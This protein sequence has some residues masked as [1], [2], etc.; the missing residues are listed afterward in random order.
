MARNRIN[1]FDELVSEIYARLAV[2]RGSAVEAAADGYELAGAMDLLKHFL[3]LGDKQTLNEGITRLER[4]FARRGKVDREWG[5]TSIARLRILAE[6]MQPS[7]REITPEADSTSLQPLVSSNPIL[8][9]PCDVLVVAALLDPELTAFLRCLSDVEQ[10]VGALD[11]ELPSVTYYRGTLKA[12]DKQ[13]GDVRKLSV[14]ALFQDRTGMVDC[15][16]LVTRAVRVFRPML[17]AMTGVC[18]GRGKAGVRLC[19]LVIPSEVFTH[20]T[21]KQ[22]DLGFQ[23]EPLWVEVS[24]RICRRVKATGET[25][26]ERL[27]KE[28]QSTYPEHLQKPRLHTE[29]MACGSAVID[30]K[31]TM[32]RVGDAHRKVVGLDMESYAVLRAVKLCSP[33]TPAFIV[34]GVMDLGTKKRDRVKSKAAFWAGSFLARFISQEYDSLRMG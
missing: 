13:P 34:K 17:V 31:D 29:V 8:P 2:R 6:D 7:D 19:D 22:G 16:V 3:A 33:M 18:A 30:H 32:T 26:L 20:D 24:D 10:V 11:G 28:I 14:A 15:A 4:V 23:A 9:T 27:G 25:I 1:D 5:K 12:P 21:G